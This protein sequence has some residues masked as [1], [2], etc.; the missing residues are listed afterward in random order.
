MMAQTIVEPNNAGT[1]FHGAKSGPT[2]DEAEPVRKKKRRM[3]K[4]ARSAAKRGM[5]SEK[6]MKK[7]VGAY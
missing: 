3:P 4:R 1:K 7:F 5:I 2:S 6:A